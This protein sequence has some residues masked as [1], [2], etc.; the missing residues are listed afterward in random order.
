MAFIVS[1]NPAFSIKAPPV[2]TFAFFFYKSKRKYKFISY[3][4]RLHHFILMM[5]AFFSLFNPSSHTPE[6]NSYL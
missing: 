5:A 1:I 6:L 3:L 4:I 2:N